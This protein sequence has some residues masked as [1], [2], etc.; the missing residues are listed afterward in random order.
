M[1][2]CWAWR[3][4]RGSRGRGGARSR[5]VD[6][7]LGVG[8]GHLD[9]R[10]LLLALTLA[11][12]PGILALGL[13][14]IRFSLLALGDLGALRRC[15]SSRRGGLRLV[16]CPL[17]FVFLSIRF[18]LALSNLS[19]SLSLRLGLLSRPLLGVETGLL[20]WRLLVL[21]L[22]LDLCFR[23]RRERWRRA[24]LN[25]VPPGIKRSV[26]RDTEYCVAA[27]P[28]PKGVDLLSATAGA[29]RVCTHFLDQVNPRA[30][31][32]DVLPLLPH[33]ILL[34]KE[35][36]LVPGLTGADG[37]ELLSIRMP[38]D[39]QHLAGDLELGQRGHAARH[40]PDRNVAATAR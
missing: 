3:G 22:R 4:S 12:G 27:L 38:G 32:H 20:R 18:S 28:E 10:V 6:V 13:L 21:G 7:L 17:D 14:L 40:I 16:P 1:V 19:L 34:L 9:G 2:G 36:H 5:H 29:N 11:L 8:G 33:P 39:V 37:R 15:S 23:R 25:R 30:A 26:V 24:L 35:V 31:H